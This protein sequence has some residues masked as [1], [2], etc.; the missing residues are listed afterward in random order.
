MRKSEVDSFIQKFYQLWKTGATA[1]LDLNT[2][3]GQ[4]W[5]GIRVQLGHVPDPV[6]QESQPRPHFKKRSPSYLKRQEK[7]RAAHSA[8]TGENIFSAEKAASKNVN[9]DKTEYAVSPENLDDKIKVESQVEPRQE[10]V[11]EKVA[12]CF[13]CDKCDFT[14][15]REDELM[16]HM[17][18]KHALIDKD[19]EFMESKQLDM[20]KNLMNVNVP[21]SNRFEILSTVSASPVLIESMNMQPISVES[22][23]FKK[24]SFSSS[25][26][27]ISCSPP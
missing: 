9:D 11:A 2:H 21:L 19:A 22:D 8:S 13:S 5:V 12:D 7:R 6:P 10:V 18:K 24:P 27:P 14:S 26:E 23:P 4:A 20:N 16:I 17:A 15:V 3:A 25:P 1:H